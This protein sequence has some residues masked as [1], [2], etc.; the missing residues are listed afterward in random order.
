MER[1]L[2]I[3]GKH[4]PEKLGWPWLEQEAVPTLA[5]CFYGEPLRWWASQRAGMNNKYR[6]ALL[7]SLL[8]YYIISFTWEITYTKSFHKWEDRGL[9]LWWLYS[10]HRTGFPPRARVMPP[11]PIAPTEPLNLLRPAHCEWKGRGHSLRPA[12]YFPCDLSLCHE[13]GPVQ[14]RNCSISWDLRAG[15][16][17]T[18]PWPPSDWHV[19]WVGNRP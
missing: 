8:N 16:P 10:I 13:T 12:R 3:A 1:I 2:V 5:C 15:R 7:Y 11:C 6:T 17:G 18:K 4:L 9:S 19:V 14:D